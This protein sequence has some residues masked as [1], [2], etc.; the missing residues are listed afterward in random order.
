MKNRALLT[1]RGW[2]LI[3]RAQ[4]I[5][6]ILGAVATVIPLMANAWHLELPSHS[7]KSEL[8]FTILMYLMLPTIIFCRV[9][10]ID[11]N[12]SWIWFLPIMLNAGICILLATL[13]GWVLSI[14]R[15]A[16]NT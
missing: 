7:A 10:G 5:G 11:A 1:W 6:G 3:R 13:F 8:V 15:G 2:S 16:T 14:F 9:F 12:V 4:V